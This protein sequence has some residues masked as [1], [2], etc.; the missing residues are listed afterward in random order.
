[1][2]STIWCPLDSFADLVLLIFEADIN[3]WYLKNS[4]TTSQE[5]GKILKNIFSR[6]FMIIQD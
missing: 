6:M 5:G 3:V 1:M 4:D 2:F